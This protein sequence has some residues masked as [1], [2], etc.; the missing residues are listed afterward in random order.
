MPAQG[1]IVLARHGRPLVGGV[2]PITGAEL[3][4]WVRRYSECGINR[5]APPPDELRQLA[6]SA[7]CIVSSDLRRSVES[8]AWLSERATIDPQLREAG[9]P[10]HISIPIRLSPGVCVVL[11]RAA[12]WLNWSRSVET[13]ADT[14]ARA[15]RV[16]VRLCA[17]AREHG[18]VLVVGHGMFN[19]FVAKCLRQR[20]W[21]GPR[22]LPRHYWSFARFVQNR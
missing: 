3:G 2:S 19:R 6:G 4:A 11:A 7:G 9:L 20:G 17:V 22:M 21:N 13:I 16:S 8:A 1:E 14:R 12:W 5:N 10:D 15:T 18:S